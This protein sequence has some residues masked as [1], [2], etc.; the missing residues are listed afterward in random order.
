MKKI[1]ITPFDLYLHFKRAQNYRQEVI[2]WSS[3][4]TFFFLSKVV[5]IPLENV[6]FPLQMG[7]AFLC[8]NNIFET[9]SPYH[10]FQVHHY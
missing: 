7:F 8:F 1:I 10:N 5:V 4:I 6:L 9:I 2:I 3:R